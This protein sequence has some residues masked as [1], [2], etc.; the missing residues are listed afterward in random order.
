M[1]KQNKKIQKPNPH[2][3][4]RATSLTKTEKAWRHSF[5]FLPLSR[6]REGPTLGNHSSRL[7]EL[8]KSLARPN[9]DISKSDNNISRR[10][11]EDGGGEDF[12]RCCAA[13]AAAH[14][15][16]HSTLW[17]PKKKNENLYC[18]TGDGGRCIPILNRTK[19]FMLK[20][21]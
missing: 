4:R 6:G 15:K 7:R 10:G 9:R 18:R 21:R 8:R 19:Q 20:E 13:A 3:A 12:R 1:H 2:L 11:R 14:R 17:R 16:Q 5:L